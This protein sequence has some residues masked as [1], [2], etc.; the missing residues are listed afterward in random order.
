MLISLIEY[1]A[2]NGIDGG[3][4]RRMAAAGR[5][6]TAQKIGRNWIIDDTEPWPVDNRITT[7][8]YK[9]WR[10]PKGEK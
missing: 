9:D 2:K 1:A 5:F 4:A 10:K 3:N 7:G 6:K 8:Q